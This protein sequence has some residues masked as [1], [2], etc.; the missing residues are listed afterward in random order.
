MGDYEQKAMQT[1]ELDDI[2]KLYSQHVII[3][4]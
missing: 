3:P 4:K 1:K 2:V